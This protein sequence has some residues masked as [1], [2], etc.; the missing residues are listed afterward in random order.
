VRE[1]FLLPRL[2]MQE[3]RLLRSLT[4]SESTPSPASPART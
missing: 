4:G 3:L 2:L 1:H